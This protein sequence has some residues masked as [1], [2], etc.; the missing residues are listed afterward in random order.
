MTNSKFRQT[1][2]NIIC[3]TLNMYNGKRVKSSEKHIDG[4]VAYCCYLV[5]EHTL[6]RCIA[7]GQIYCVIDPFC[8]MSTYGA[9][10]LSIFLVLILL[11]AAHE[12]RFSMIKGRDIFW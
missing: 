9:I 5:I 11:F 2:K 1:K 6:S 7:E 12:S 8:I 4:P 10:L 3:Q